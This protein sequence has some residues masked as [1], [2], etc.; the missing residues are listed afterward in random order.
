LDY[1]VE[2][3]R[4]LA[5]RVRMLVF[6]ARSEQ[7]VRIDS[8]HFIS[9]GLRCGADLYLPDGV[10]APPVILM[11]HGFAGERSA[12][13]PA[14][15]E[16]FCQRGYAVFLFDYRTFGDSEGSPSQLV[17]PGHHLQDWRAA[18]DHVRSLSSVDA[19]RLVLWGTSF[20][21]GHVVQTASEDHG[22]TAII[23]Q[24]PFTSGL[25]LL[26]QYSPGDALHMT[27]AGVRDLL[28]SL[29]GAKPYHY[30]VV[31]RPGEHAMMNTPESYDGYLG[32]FEPDTGWENRVPARIALQI[33]FYSPAR[34]AAR[35]QCPALVIAGLNDSLIPVESVRAMA[36]RMPRGTCVELPCNHFEPYSGEA[37]EQNIALQLEFLDKNVRDL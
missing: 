3:G 7:R 5:T 23:A 1:R 14:F 10:R 28:G 30:P 37:F 29:L 25:A 19:D 35:V 2:S 15:A 27:V 21:G 11:A 6:A 16:R 17:S 36:G 8:T 33:P 4:A 24:V 18:I 9:A 26:R 20:S 13:L 12:R 34:A 31:G 22:V 32:L